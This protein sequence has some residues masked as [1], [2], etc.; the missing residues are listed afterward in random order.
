[1]S[2]GKLFAIGI[3]ILVAIGAGTAQYFWK[4]RQASPAETIEATRARVV[5]DTTERLAKAWAG[6]CREQGAP[7]RDLQALASATDGLPQALAELGRVCEGQAPELVCCYVRPVPR[8]LAQ[9]PLFV[10]HTG[11]DHHVVVRADG[12]SERLEE[13]ADAWWVKA[14]SLAKLAA[15]DDRGI[16]AAEWGDAYLE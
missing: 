5:E 11:R 1:M 13:D 12:R 14:T 16:T 9:Q 4:L 2:R 3:F 6:Y 8:P 7:P 10:I 15:H